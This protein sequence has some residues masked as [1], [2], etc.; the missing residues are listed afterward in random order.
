MI[1]RL[2][3][4]NFHSIRERQVIDLRVADNAPE[5]GARLAPLWPGASERAPKV[6]TLFGPNASGKSNVLRALSFIAWFV[7]DSFQLPPDRPVPVMRFLSDEAEAEPVRLAVHFA[8]PADP[9][10]DAAPGAPLCRY[11]YDV[12]FDGD[13]GQLLVVREVLRYWPPPAGRPVKLFDRGPD[14]SVKAAQAFG[15]G[16]YRQALGKI[17]RQNASVVSTLAQVGHPGASRLRDAAGHVV[18]N[19]P[20]DARPFSDDVIAR[21]YAANPPLVQ[22]LN[23]QI[24]RIDLGIRAMSVQQGPQGPVALFEHEG[25]KEPVVFALESHGTRRFVGVLPYLQQALSTGGIAVIDEL[26]LAIHPLVLPELLRWF[27]DPARNPHNA[28]LWMACQ[29][30]SLMDD[31]TKEEILLCAK[32]TRGRTRVWCLADVQGVR[33]DAN[34]QRKYLGGAYGAIPHLG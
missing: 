25:L 28:Q 24:S 5:D 16:G 34:H 8:G 15:L 7:R 32:D 11:A 23:R 9:A 17:L 33:R 21:H 3:I 1:H 22:E 14:G 10:A 13:P 2:E 4:E 6:V 19:I 12:A 29:N 31:L 30:A 27:H 18:S 26:D 20:A